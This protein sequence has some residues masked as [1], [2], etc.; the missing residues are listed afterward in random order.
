M[1]YFFTLVFSLLT[2]SSFCQQKTIDWKFE[3]K[4]TAPQTY[5]IKATASIEEGWYIYSQY[6]ESDTGPIATY[7]SFEEA[8]NTQL[9]GN[10]SEEGKKITSWDKLFDMSIT[11]YKQKMV[12][13]HLIKVPKG[14]RY[15]KGSITFMSCNDRQCMPPRSVA[16]EVKLPR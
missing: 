9:L 2:L 5:K 7:W 14:Q 12:L 1:N 11:K 6:L 8:E 3:A 10:P 13:E 16:F 4:R 15:S